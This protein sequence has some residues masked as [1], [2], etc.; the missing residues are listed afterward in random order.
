MLPVQRG[1]SPPLKTSELAWD[2][3]LASAYS[4][5]ALTGQVL[6]LYSCMD[7]DGT[8]GHSDKDQF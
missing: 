1:K 2:G 3:V 4:L 5:E 7:G 8:Y 6:V